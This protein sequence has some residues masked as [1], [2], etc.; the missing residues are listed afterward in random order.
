MAFLHE[1]AP[2]GMRSLRSDTLTMRVTGVRITV[3]CSAIVI[4]VIV[5]C[6]TA[7][8]FWVKRQKTIVPIIVWLGFWSFQA[9]SDVD[10]EVYVGDGIVGQEAQEALAGDRRAIADADQAGPLDVSGQTRAAQALRTLNRPQTLQA[11]YTT[12]RMSHSETGV[13]CALRA[14]DEV[15]YTVEL[16]WTRRQTPCPSSRRTTCSYGP[17]RRVRLSHASY[18][19]KRAVEQWSAS[20]VRGKE[21]TRSWRRKSCVS[22]SPTVFL[23]QCLYSATKKWVSSMCAENLRAKGRREQCCDLRQKR[24][25]RAT[26]LSKRCTDTYRDSHD[27]TRHKS[28]RTTGTVTFVHVWWI[29]FRVAPWP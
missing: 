23:I 11:W 6:H 7:G 5:H 17:W 2:C 13:L 1:G 28:R 26:G 20:C 9:S 12:R 21:D 10:E 27:A 29:G 18:S 16:W 24:V 3:F 19:W 14:E 4:V 22:L 8:A 25:I 15:L